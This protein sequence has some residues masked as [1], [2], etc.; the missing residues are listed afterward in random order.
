MG[1]RAV[2]RVGFLHR[3]ALTKIPGFSQDRPCGFRPRQERFDPFKSGVRN[4]GTM[5][6]RHDASE[7]WSCGLLLHVRRLIFP[8]VLKLGVSDEAP[9]SY[10]AK[11]T[12]FRPP[13]FA[14]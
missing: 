9:D 7:C 13:A 4:V 2:E 5:L 8:R 6:L 12:L 11:T 1:L 10:G 14:A 3:A